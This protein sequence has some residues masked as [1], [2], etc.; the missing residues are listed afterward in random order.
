MVK[1][2][3]FTARSSGYSASCILRA[4]RTGTRALSLERGSLL[5]ILLRL[6]KVRTGLWEHAIERLKALDIEKD[7]AELEPVLKAIEEKLTELCRCK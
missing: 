5:D 2:R 1:S 6:Q 7:A 4:L 3:K